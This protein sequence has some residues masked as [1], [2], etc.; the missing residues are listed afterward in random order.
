MKKLFL[1]AAVCTALFIALNPL[2]IHGCTSWI[3]M[4]DMTA[5]GTNI[6][7]K[8]RDAT[9]KNV[10]VYL[11]PASSPRKWIGSG[12]NGGVYMGM[13]SSGLGVIMNNGEAY[14]NVRNSTA[15]NRK[16]TPII[17]RECL[18]QCDTAAQAVEYFKKVITDKLYYHPSKVGAI[19]LICDRNE[20][21]VCEFTDS[22]ISVQKYTEGFTVRAN[23]WQNPG[24]YQ[25]ARNS[26]KKYLN[27]STRAFIALAGLN[28]I[29]DKNGKIAMLDIFTLSRHC[30]MPD[31]SP[32]EQTAAKKE[33]NTDV[34]STLYGTKRSICFKY[35]NSISSF[36]IDRRYPD[37]LSTM[38]TTIGHPRHTV[39]VP[40]PVCVE[41]ILP[42][43][44]N[45]KWSAAAFKRLDKLKLET[46][47]PAEWTKFEKDSMAVYQ[48]AQSDARKLLNAGKRAEAVK[49]VNSTAEKIWKDA[50]KLLKI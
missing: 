35:T 40:V 30:A 25:L 8:N 31:N 28:Q 50:V 29:I 5:N 46:P 47:I 21:Y 38:Y 2:N 1:L 15:K 23:I 6:V 10:A 13:N 44:G 34:L 27:S 26:V 18:E 16:T 36:E 9:P 4:H 20:G 11:S 43:M 32:A 7:H 14:V 19:Y 3:I 45:L 41:K 39:Y 22:R 48:K 12:N 42:S 17:I 49:L 37:V 24:M 33:S